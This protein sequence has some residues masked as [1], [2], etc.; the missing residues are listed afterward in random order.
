MMTSAGMALNKPAAKDRGLDG[1]GTV[2]MVLQQQAQ[3]AWV[4][5]VNGSAQAASW[6]GLDFKPSFTAIS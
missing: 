3:A 4:D 6:S 2:E 5:A 1:G